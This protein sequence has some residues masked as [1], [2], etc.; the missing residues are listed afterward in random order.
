MPF[1]ASWPP[2]KR[3]VRPLVVIAGPAVLAGPVV[4]GGPAALAGWPRSADGGPS[5]AFP[6]LISSR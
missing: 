4:L 5:P 1:T 6:K 3:L 2:R